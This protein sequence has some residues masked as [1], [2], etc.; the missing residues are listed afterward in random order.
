V[1]AE[2]RPEA[3]ELFVRDTGKGFDPDTVPADREGLRSSIR[4]RMARIGGEAVVESAP[5]EGAEVEL[6]LARSTP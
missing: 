2:V 5:G 6:R 3:V 1:F 4:A